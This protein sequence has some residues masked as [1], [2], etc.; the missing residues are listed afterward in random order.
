MQ[1]FNISPTNVPAKL[2][3]YKEGFER[4]ASDFRI[5]SGNDRSEDKLKGNLARIGRM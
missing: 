2:S 4:C 3:I 5:E 1:P